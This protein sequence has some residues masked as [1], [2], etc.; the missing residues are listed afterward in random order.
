MTGIKDIPDKLGAL[1]QQPNKNRPKTAENDLFK[2]TFD[3]AL[4]G[5]TK[6]P[7]QASS[8]PPLG[9]INA[10]RF[11]TVESPDANISNKTGK[12]LDKLDIYSQKLANPDI[13]LREIEPLINEIKGEA[14]ALSL[15]ASKGGNKNPELQRIANESALSANTEYIKF[16]RGDYV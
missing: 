11:N 8:L 15:E 7:E 9:E 6:K 4:A 13:S 1:Q 12:L 5:A 3:K 2:T 16:M 10:I 14:E